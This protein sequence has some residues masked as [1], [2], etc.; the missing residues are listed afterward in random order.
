MIV[1]FLRYL[2]SAPANNLIADAL[3]NPLMISEKRFLLIPLYGVSATEIDLVGD[4]LKIHNLELQLSSEKP[5][6]TIV[7]TSLPVE[8][9]QSGWIMLNGGTAYPELAL[10][11]ASRGGISFTDESILLQIVKHLPSDLKLMVRNT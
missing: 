10:Q 11:E 7:S 5:Y 6:C 9:S 8:Y 1:T 3:D 2:L 4:V